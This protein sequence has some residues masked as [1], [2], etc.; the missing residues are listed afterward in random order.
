MYS[1]LCL[2]SECSVAYSAP[3]TNRSD[4]AWPEQWQ[5]QWHS[6][7]AAGR[8]ASRHAGGQ[9]CMQPHGTGGTCMQVLLPR[10]GADQLA[11]TTGRLVRWSTQRGCQHAV[12]LL[13]AQR[14][15]MVQLEGPTKGAAHAAHRCAA[16]A[17]SA[18]QQCPCRAHLV[19]GCCWLVMARD[20]VCL[21]VHG[22]PG[23][24]SRLVARL[25]AATATRSEPGGVS[26]GVLDQPYEWKAISPN[27][28]QS[29]AV[30]GL[31][32]V[33]ACWRHL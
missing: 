20:G 16:V 28:K 26:V 19:I 23:T 11:D 2:L 24:I 13:L 22:A 8:Q 15:D 9:C 21:A 25:V 31:C 6:Q 32:R 17:S 33:L 3:D 30:H 10:C 7:A 18:L 27:G 5:Q 4:V 29:D 14:C 1:V 12:P